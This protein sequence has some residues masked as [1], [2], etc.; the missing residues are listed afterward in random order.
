[1]LF[2]RCIIIISLFFAVGAAR[3]REISVWLALLFDYSDNLN[4]NEYVLGESL[5][6]N[7]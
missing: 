4:L 7:A 6:C 3:K 1:M 2:V 5:C